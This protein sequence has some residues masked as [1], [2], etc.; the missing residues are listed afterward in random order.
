MDHPFHNGNKRTA[1][2]SM[3]AHLDRNGLCLY[4]TSQSDLYR[5]MVSIADHSIGVRL[6]P[7][8][9]DKT[10]ARRSADDEVQAIV[11][12]LSR[13][14]E[15]VRRGEKPITY[16]HL[17]QALGPFGYELGTI[18][19]NRVEIVKVETE[20]PGLL[21]RQP[22]TVRRRIGL[23]GYRNE[24]TE[25]SVKDLKAVRRMCKLTEA[26]GVD[27]DGFYDHAAVVDSFVNK[28]R[29]VLRRLAK[30]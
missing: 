4:G 25:V 7:R 20:K 8:R 18:A 28:Y 22:R 9:K 16:R 29:T 14:V 6:D 26:D 27:T 13:R 23:I 30:T 1:L 19:S 2:V 21:R 10:P 12:W 24:G 3:L 15:E 17:R 11:E 5:F